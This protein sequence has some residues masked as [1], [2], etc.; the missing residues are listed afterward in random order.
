[1]L[2]LGQFVE[3]PAEPGER[4]PARSDRSAASASGT[5]QPANSGQPMQIARTS[6]IATAGAGARIAPAQMAALISDVTA[7]TSK[8]SRGRADTAGGHAANA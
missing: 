8:T 1:M 4:R 7:A 5:S 3:A 2:G 6:G